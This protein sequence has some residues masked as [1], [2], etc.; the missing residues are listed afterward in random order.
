MLVLI[1]TQDPHGALPTDRHFAVEGELVVP[2]VFECPDSHCDV[3]ARA[4]FGL[5]SHAGTT[6]AMVADRPG[7]TRAKLRQAIHDWLDRQGTIDLVVQAV[8][9]GGFELEGVSI[10]DPV[11]AVS[12]LVDDQ[13]AVIEAV[14]AEFGEGAIVSRMGSLVS[15]R[16]RPMAA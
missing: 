4:W 3:C 7:V 16:V 14:C 8:E 10:H 12:D 2:A 5:V 6:T 15:Q 9:A 11:A 13:I 1:A